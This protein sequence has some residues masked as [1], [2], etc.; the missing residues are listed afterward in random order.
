MRFSL[1]SILAMSIATIYNIADSVFIGKYVGEE[2]LG[3]LTVAFPLIMC[4]SAIGALLGVG[5]PSMVSIRLGENRR[6]EA[7]LF[8]GNTLLLIIIVSIAQ[9]IL[10]LIFCEPLMW[11]SGAS[12]NNLPYA[13]AYMSSQ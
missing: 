1:P 3:R 4:L 13:V 11:M 5:G 10:A 7:H 6:D 9:S 8:F 2:A 12:E